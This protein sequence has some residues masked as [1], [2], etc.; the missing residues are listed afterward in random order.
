MASQGK[1]R[2]RPTKEIFNRLMSRPAQAVCQQ[3]LDPAAQNTE[4]AEHPGGRYSLTH[5]HRHPITF[6]A[7]QARAVDEHLINPDQALTSLLPRITV[8]DAVLQ[9]LGARDA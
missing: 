1:K 3:R 8:R 4:L 2:F 5:I 6:R 9:V 7:P